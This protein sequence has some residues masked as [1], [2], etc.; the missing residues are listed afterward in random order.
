MQ[1]FWQ[2]HLSVRCRTYDKS[3]DIKVASCGLT[4]KLWQSQAKTK[5]AHDLLKPIYDWFTEGL[6]TPDLK[7]ARALLDELN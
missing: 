3:D 6:D 2:R 1:D 4:K 5:E 7:E